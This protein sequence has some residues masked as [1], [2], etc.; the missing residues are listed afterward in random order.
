MTDS[1]GTAVV[2]SPSAPA[3]RIE[4][5]RVVAEAENRTCAVVDATVRLWVNGVRVIASGEGTNAVDALENGLL[6]A[7][8]RAAAAGC[9]I[10][11]AELLALRVRSGILAVPTFTDG[12]TVRVTA[13]HEPAMV[14]RLAAL[15]GPHA[16]DRF[17]YGCGADGIARAV[18]C[19]LGDRWQAERVAAKLRRVIGVLEVVVEDEPQPS[20]D[21]PD[22]QN[23]SPSPA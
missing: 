8:A 13:V 16:V 23:G 3:P 6:A 10:S 14:S 21:R 18:L 15:L 7:S 12:T 22:R 20:D 11:E 19:V 4:S 1:S 5:W 17:S 2:P 9:A